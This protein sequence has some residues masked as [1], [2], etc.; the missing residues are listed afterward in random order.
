MPVVIVGLILVLVL[1]YLGRHKI[2][3]LLGMATPVPAEQITETTNPTPVAKGNTP[4]N[5][6][7]MSK[8]DAAKGNYLTDFEGKTLYTYDKDTSG[9]SNCEGACL[10]AWP[11]YTSGATAQGTMPANISVIT[12]S[13]G[14]KQFAWK[15]MP[16]YYFSGD[17]KSG[18]INGD[19]VGGVWHIIKL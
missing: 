18:D 13:D 7:Y 10:T 2:K 16:L 4:S 12:R 14:S 1:G 3:A 6:I 11:A 5:N 9:V 8:T 17:S 19:G 15:G